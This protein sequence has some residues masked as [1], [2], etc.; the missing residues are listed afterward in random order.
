MDRVT[1]HC[2]KCCKYPKF[3]ILF[4]SQTGNARAIAESISEQCEAVGLKHD[5]SC[6]SGNESLL[7][8]VDCL[9]FVGSTTGDGDPPDTARKFWRSINKKDR[10]CNAFAHLSYTVLGLGDT[11]Y[12]NFCNFGKSIDRR[13]E[14]L[15]AKRFYPCGWADD[16]TGLEEVVE[17]WIEELLPAIKEHLKY[18]GSCT[19]S[20]CS[21]QSGLNQD[22]LNNHTCESE[23]SVI[24]KDFNKRVNEASGEKTDFIM[25]KPENYKDVAE[26]DAFEIASKLGLCVLRKEQLQCLSIKSCHFSTDNKLSIPVLP[27]AYLVLNF[28]ED[29]TDD[30]A[31]NFKIS[32]LNA[33]S[34]V[35]KMKLI[36]LKQLTTNDA[37]KTAFEVTLQFQDTCNTFDYSPGDSF[38]IIVKNPRAEVDLLLR[39]L[40]ISDVADKTYELTIDSATKKKNASIPA[41]IPA[42]SSLRYVFENCVDLRAVPKKPLMRTLIEYTSDP[43]EKQRLKELVSK[44]GGSEYN[45]FVR[46]CNLT[47]ID[48]L[49]IF[50]SC[51]P[52]VTSLLEHLPQLQPRAY[53][54]ISSPLSDS[55]KISFAFNV[56]EMKEGETITFPRKGICTGWLSSYVNSIAEKQN[57]VDDDQ[58]N[59]AFKNLTL[60]D[61]NVLIDVYLRSNQSFHLPKDNSIPIVMVGPGTGVAP[62]VG[63]L[64]HRQ[65]MRM[66][67]NENA[68]GESWLFF[69]CRHK[70]KDYLYREELE[71]FHRDKVLSHLKVCFSR[72][73]D[74][75]QGLKYVQDNIILHGPDLVSL[76]VNKGA[77]IYVC[78][79]AKNMA[80]NVFEAFTSIL[81]V[82]HN[83]SAVEARKYIAQM[84]IDKRYLQDV[85]A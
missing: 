25:E 83:L 58:L 20:Q 19:G 24:D 59:D 10:S 42:V 12:T 36:S 43:N 60:L 61:R 72:D 26:L 67:G 39:L 62:F 35:T 1:L 14:N 44:E 49:L 79:D 64:K 28:R 2:K 82:N 11:N 57:L 76:I 29:L 32:L 21:N 65:M 75:I 56:I 4:A 66:S 15:G 45:R 84:Q 85:W 69:G 55:S 41:F 52:S 18:K 22:P 63:F 73:E 53:S 23:L 8:N 17:P 16:G 13:F 31:A 33:A 70:N 74:S 3:L 48:L 54:A 27:P 71:Q 80:K 78:G 77:I 5:I 51:K 34:S 68:F 40:G 30:S 6:T 47:L 50:Q 9:V 7:D 37:V 38:G 46:E 81:E